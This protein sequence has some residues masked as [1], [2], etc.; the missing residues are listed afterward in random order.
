MAAAHSLS[1]SV[2]FYYGGAM[3]L[4]IIVVMLIILFQVIVYLI[5][6]F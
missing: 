3:T 4:G 6:Y 2:V 5:N 1:Q